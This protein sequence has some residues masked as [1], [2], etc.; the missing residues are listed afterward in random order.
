MVNSRLVFL[1]R[2]TVGRLSQ[3]N[4]RVGSEHS[5]I[6]KP[7]SNKAEKRIGHLPLPLKRTLLRPVLVW[8]PSP[9]SLPRTLTN[10]FLFYA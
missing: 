10:R 8:I 6:K 3:I 4:Q 7:V 2:A 9:F 5:K 1:E